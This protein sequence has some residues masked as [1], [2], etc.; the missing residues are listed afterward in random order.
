MFKMLDKARGCKNVQEK[1]LPKEVEVEIAV[2]ED[3][4][5]A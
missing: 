5:Q 3:R 1:V 4:W 2:G